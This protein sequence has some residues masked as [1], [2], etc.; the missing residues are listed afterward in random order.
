MSE[1]N[2]VRRAAGPGSYLRWTLMAEIQTGRRSVTPSLSITRSTL[3]RR[4]ARPISLS[5]ELPPGSP[6]QARS[7]TA[8]SCRAS[9]RGATNSPAACSLFGINR[10]CKW[11]ET[12]PQGQHSSHAGQSVWLWISL[13]G[14]SMPK[15][16][17]ILPQAARLIA[18]D[19]QHGIV[20]KSVNAVLIL[21]IEF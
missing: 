12:T 21:M 15:F 17:G 7:D 6:G 5:A 8:R 16:F 18:S 20:E 19:L 10:F 1:H 11:T 4:S 14:P 9:L 3:A 2:A 13:Y